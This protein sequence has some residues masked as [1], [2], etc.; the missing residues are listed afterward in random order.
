MLIIRTYVW[1]PQNNLHAILR[2]IVH[3]GFIGI[4]FVF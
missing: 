1:N 2:T 3:E 4:K